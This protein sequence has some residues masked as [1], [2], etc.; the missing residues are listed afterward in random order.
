MINCPH[1]KRLTRSALRRD[2]VYGPVCVECYK[3]LNTADMVESVNI[4][5]GKKI[6]IEKS[7]RGTCCDPATE[8]YHCM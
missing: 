5:S 8:R 2:D 3:R 6:K 4:L 1:C 7:L